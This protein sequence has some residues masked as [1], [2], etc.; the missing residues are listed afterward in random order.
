M[1]SP[2]MQ[3]DMLTVRFLFKYLNRIN[4]YGNIEALFQNL[5]K[6]WCKTFLGSMKRI[7]VMT[8]L[9]QSTLAAMSM[10]DFTID[11]STVWC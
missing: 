2:S 5:V 4:Y 8:D 10:G 6:I 9:Q 3:T 11:F 1:S 7:L